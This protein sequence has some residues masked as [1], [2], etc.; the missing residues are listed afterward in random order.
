MKTL[1]VALFWLL[2]GGCGGSGSPAGGELVEAHDVPYPPPAGGDASMSLLDIYH[3]PGGGQRL[4]VFVHG[5]SWVGGDKANLRGA[6]DLVRW[7][8]ERGW[9][10]AAPNFR[11][12]SGPGQP[13]DVTYADQCADVAG[14]LAW[15]QDHRADYGVTGPG[16]LL[17]GY[18]S[19][20][21][22]VALLAA[23]ESYLQ[24][25]GVSHAHLAG[26][27]SLDVHAYDVPY[28]LALMKGSRL[29]DNIP[30]IEHLFGTTEA[31]Q[32]IGSPSSY[33]PDAKVPPSLLISAGP[34]AERGSHGHIASS[35]TR[36]YTELL[37][38][39]GH[40]ASFHHYN[41]ETH[42][43]LVLDFG[44]EG[45][46]PTAAVGDFLNEL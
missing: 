30:L 16:M 39:A 29:E 4:V 31:E 24:S 8:T 5:G 3:L 2:L 28:A 7:F 18:S 34:P 37:Q 13:R 27:V 6:P 21:H 10:V 12:A 15:L 9:V 44:T 19:G 26:A 35:A 42:A 14:A 20:A 40:R 43:S 23:D 32:R 22:L 45:D 11:L 38:A 1:C 25:A 36:R 17:V 33:A 46:G 41:H